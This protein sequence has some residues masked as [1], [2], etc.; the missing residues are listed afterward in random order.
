[1][2]FSGSILIF[3]NKVKIISEC[4]E[5]LNKKF[6]KASKEIL[7]VIYKYILIT[8]RT[9]LISKKCLSGLYHQR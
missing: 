7:R 9:Q 2:T 3:V 5:R 6:L 4:E 1:M 8:N